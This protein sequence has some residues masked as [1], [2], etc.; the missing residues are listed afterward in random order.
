MR[1]VYVQSLNELQVSVAQLGDQVAFAL[2]RTWLA[3]S[4]FDTQIADEIYKG[5]DVIDNLVRDCMRKDLNIGVMESPVGSDWRYLM[6]S[7]KILTELERIADHCADIS[8]YVKHLAAAGDI[9]PPPLGMKA[10]YDVM[11]AMVNDVMECY[12]TNDD[13]QVLLIKDKDDIVDTA[14]NQIINL[15]AQ[16]MAADPQHIHQYIAYVLITKY[17]ERMADHA[18]NIAD[19]VIYKKSNKLK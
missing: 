9:V 19:W 16:Q 14:F 4:T 6:G 2:D 1:D 3:L 12:Q 17:I 18:G 8:H 15:L 7:L 10:M 11:T 13:E 5:D